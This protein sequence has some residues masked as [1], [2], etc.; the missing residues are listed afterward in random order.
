MNAHEKEE[1]IKRL[2]RLEERMDHLL[3]V[4]ERATGMWIMARW[5]GSA[6]A[7]LVGGY[8]WFSDHLKDVLHLFTQK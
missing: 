2:E 8:L 1:I 5:V 6:S 7:V 3:V 4:V